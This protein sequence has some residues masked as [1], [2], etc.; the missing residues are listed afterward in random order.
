MGPLRFMMDNV[1]FCETMNV[2]AWTM[3][4]YMGIVLGE[5]VTLMIYACPACDDGMKIVV[6]YL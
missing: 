3:S 6:L 2:Y 4:L 1:I 5:G